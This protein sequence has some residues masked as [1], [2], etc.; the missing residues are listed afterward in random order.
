MRKN[1]QKQSHVT[2]RSLQN[3]DDELVQLSSINWQRMKLSQV[4]YEP[5]EMQ[6]WEMRRI[7][8]PS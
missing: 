8:F 2:E 6:V 4:S 3:D 5:Q 7:Q 1:D